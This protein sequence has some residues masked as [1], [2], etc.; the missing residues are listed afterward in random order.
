MLAVASDL[1]YT[2]RMTLLLTDPASFV[3]ILVAPTLLVL[4]LVGLAYLLSPPLGA[5][6][7]WVWRRRGYHG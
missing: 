6:Q 7:R 1:W 2:L 5:L 4:F 3:F